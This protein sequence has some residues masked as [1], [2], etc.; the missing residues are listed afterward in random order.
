MKKT[1]SIACVLVMLMAVKAHGD[2]NELLREFEM[3]SPPAHLLAG[4]DAGPIPERTPE[5][6]AFSDEKKRIESAIA[7][8]E[9]VLLSTDQGTVFY[10][11]D[12]QTLE[13]FRSA[14]GD[15][16]AAAQAI[17]EGFSLETLE[18]LVLLR[19]PG[20]RAEE[21]RF[22]AAIEG[23]R[24][25]SAL[26][27][28]LRR[29][30]AFTEDLKTGVGPMKGK[31]PVKMKFPFP[32]VLSLKGEIVQQE[33]RAARESLE[34]ARR[35][36]VT[37]SRITFWNLLYNRKAQRTLSET[38]DLLKH[39]EEVATTRYEAG[40]TSF[41]DVI[42][43]GIE[44]DILG[45]KL[46]TFKEK[47][48]NI[49]AGL[50]ELLYLSPR[51]RLGPPDERE[52]PKNISPLETLYELALERRQELRRRRAAISKME[53]MIEMAETMI[54]PPF[55]LNLSLYEDEAVAK[56]GSQSVKESFPVR[57]KASKGAGLPKMPWYGAN[58]AY[59]RHTRQRLLAMGEDLKKAEANTLTL[60]RKAWFEFDRA[61]REER[62][63]SKRVVKRSEAA[64]A[65]S[66]RGY[67]SG[68]VSFPDVISS[69]TL[70]LK[71]RLSAKKKRSDIGVALA[72]LERIVGA[73]LK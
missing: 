70:W 25:V 45:E 50:L 36:A 19:N 54:L 52:P 44:R 1:L 22:R 18:T 49:E 66:S 4:E 9:K 41:Q 62:L 56:V 13:T 58:D 28:I 15:D 14:G 40:K 21:K 16:R 57:I 38:L 33:V 43:V 65:V 72:E 31:D 6:K 48:R 12:S 3:Y 71:A 59:L 7:G 35:D 11:P 30:T 64:L 67:E 8:W 5:D 61:I 34:A 27:E 29:Y 2:Y 51:V 60:V 20:I 10:R 23:F 46:V 68:N 17:G 69:Y 63:F 39:L 73:P 24:Q 32:G 26:D 42:K 47:Q 55:T 53:R 37:S